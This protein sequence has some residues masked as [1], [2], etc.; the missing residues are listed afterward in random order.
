[1]TTSAFALAADIDSRLNEMRNI[2]SRAEKAFDVDEELYDILCRAGSILLV[3]A[4]EGFIKDL[5]VALQTDLNLNIENFSA[6]PKKMQR[7]FANK[8][9]Y[10]DNVPDAER[11][12]RSSQI[13][14]FF[15]INSVNIDMNAF[16]YKENLNKNPSSNFIDSSFAKYGIQSALH[17]LAGSRFEVVFDN[18]TATDVVL[19]REIRRMRATLFHFPYRALPEK[20]E[21]VDWAP[22]RGRVIPNSLW[23]TYLENISGRR[24]TIVHAD[25]QANPTS[26]QILKD[27]TNK[28]EVMFNALLLAV[29]SLLGRDL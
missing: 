29:A 4:L 23:H 1:M 15:E 11:H 13:L 9:A 7:E 5:N 18:D 25:T 17:C 10:Y 3:S 16:P 6:M 8:M 21:L 26:W 19:R 24:H 14:K 2:V 12:R 28:M 22:D 20:F 27:D